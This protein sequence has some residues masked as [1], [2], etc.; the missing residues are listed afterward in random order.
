VDLTGAHTRGKR[1]N[2]GMEMS[3]K[4]VK[5]VNNDLENDSFTVGRWSGIHITLH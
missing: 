2:F 4:V 3:G 1:M 5:N